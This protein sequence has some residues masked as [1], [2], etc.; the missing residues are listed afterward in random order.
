MPRPSPEEPQIQITVRVPRSLADR[1]A[2]LAEKIGSTA[3]VRVSP[4][5]VH[6][7]LLVSAIE[8]KERELGLAKPT[9]ARGG[10]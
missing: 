8:A 5:E 1:L 9:K 10:K 6:R 2:A 3:G 4:T 7:S